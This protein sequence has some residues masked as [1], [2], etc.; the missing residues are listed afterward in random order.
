M[1]AKIHENK[2]RELKNELEYIYYEYDVFKRL[3]STSI[4]KI[5]TFI[6]IVIFIYYYVIILR[7]VFDKSLLIKLNSS[8]IHFF[9]I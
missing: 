8:I 1:I 6:Y 2:S 7:R 5:I 9:V 3:C 4:K